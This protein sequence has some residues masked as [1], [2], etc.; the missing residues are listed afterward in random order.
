MIMFF[1]Q[2]RIQSLLQFLTSSDRSHFYEYLKPYIQSAATEDVWRTIPMIDRH[3]VEKVPF[4]DRCFIHPEAVRYTSGTSGNAVLVSPRVYSGRFYDSVPGAYRL[5]P[6][7][8]LM[9]FMFP[10]LYG[11]PMFPNNIRTVAGHSTSMVASAKLAKLVSVTALNIMPSTVAPFLEALE[12]IGYDLH[13]LTHI[14][15]IGERCSEVHLQY[16]H[17]MLPHASVLICYGSSEFREVVACTCMHQCDAKQEQIIVPSSEFFFE[18]ID[19]STGT[20]I[21]DLGVMGELVVTNLSV[22]TPFPLVRYRTG[23]IAQR[24]DISCACTSDGYG[25]VLGGRV[26]IFP[27]RITLGEISAP[28][29][30][31]AL[32][33]IGGVRSDYYEAEFMSVAIDGS[34]KPTVHFKVVVDWFQGDDTSLAHRIQSVLRVSSI[35]TYSDGVQKGYYHPISVERIP[36]PVGKS[37]APTPKISRVN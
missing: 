29:I 34:V 1:P 12:R 22:D 27:I 36:M 17:R 8:Y 25:Y 5:P 19:P 24:V 26:S 16:L 3:N 23:D 21:T 32:S 33:S 13:Q 6:D 28:L 35:T 20:I 14:I 4:P 10:S 31:E 37:K 9:N 2:H 7:A 18:L 15:L 30:E 11:A